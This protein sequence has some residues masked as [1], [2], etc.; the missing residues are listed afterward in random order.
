[1]KIFYTKFKSYSLIFLIV[2]INSC[3][4]NKEYYGSVNK[5]PIK[6]ES[7][8]NL[9][10]NNL[11]EFQ[12]ENNFSPDEQQ[13][14]QIANDTWKRFV[15]GNILLGLY[16]KYNIS[17]SPREVLD[18]LRTNIPP[19]LYE[20]PRFRNDYNEFDY[21]RYYSSLNNDTPENLISIKN[22]YL[23]TYIPRKK[24]ENAIVSQRTFTD[25]EI[26]NYIEMENTSVAANLYVFYQKHIPKNKVN[27]TDEEIED[28]YS[29]NRLNYYVETELDINWVSIGLQPSEK[30]KNFAWVKADSL[31]NELKNGVNFQHIANIHSAQP[32]GRLHGIMGFMEYDEFPDFIAETLRQ[33]PVNQVLRPCFYDN[34]WWIYKVEDKTPNMIKP[35]IIKIDIKLS[36]NT[37]EDNKKTIMTFLDIQ[38]MLGFQRAASELSLTVFQKEKMN[39]R[40]NYIEGIGDITNVLMELAKLP[41]KAIYN[42]IRVPDSD[43]YIIFQIEKKTMGYFKSLYAV[44][45]EIVETLTNEKLLIQATNEAELYKKRASSIVPLVKPIVIDI[46]NNELPSKFVKEA[47]QTNVEESTNVYSD[48]SSA[49]FAV[50]KSKYQKKITPSTPDEREK[51]IIAMQ[52]IDKKEYFDDWYNAQKKK[53]KVIDKRPKNLR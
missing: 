39:T 2:F 13:K 18:S 43:C 46:K 10:M 32:F 12:K 31:Y 9:Y 42:P 37:I 5:E 28:Y 24:L 26:N 1:M 27:I 3:A 30:D 14:K 38:N 16:K 19:S 45:D 22:F 25:K 52:N 33:T 47:I 40:N 49:F 8:I 21:E 7:F 41:E 4:T 23:S 15:E 53:A 17:V 34:A 35:S 44:M 50:V 48:D 6:S 36:R 51:I 29:A 11:E 20:S